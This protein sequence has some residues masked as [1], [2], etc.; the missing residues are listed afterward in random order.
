M[1]KIKIIDSESLKELLT[2]DGSVGEGWILPRKG[3]IVHVGERVWRSDY[4]SRYKPFTGEV[5]K[6][7]H[8]F[9][10]N[11]QWSLHEADEIRIFIK[12]V[13]KDDNTTY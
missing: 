6:I 1:T 3:D 8:I 7:T 9:D 5:I 2:S 10:Y 13:N 11:S 4:D 12:K